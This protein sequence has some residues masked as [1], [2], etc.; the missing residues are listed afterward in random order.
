MKSFWRERQ[1][2]NVPVRVILTILLL[3]TSVLLA[4][5]LP[6]VKVGSSQTQQTR[7]ESSVVTLP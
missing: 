4:N 5:Y 2:K 1:N 3:L 6:T 7:W